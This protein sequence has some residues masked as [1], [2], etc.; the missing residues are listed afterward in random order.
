M[1]GQTNA[2]CLQS[3]NSIP[4]AF[5]HGDRNEICSN[6]CSFIGSSS[7]RLSAVKKDVTPPEMGLLC[8]IKLERGEKRRRR[9]CNLGSPRRGF[10]AC[11]GVKD[12]N[13]MRV[14][15]F[16]LS[17]PQEREEMWPQM[18]KDMAAYE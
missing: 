18:D 10:K 16:L 9:Q 1:G 17:I 7:F 8:W 5:F 3:S 4:A 15:S 12:L 13:F 6:S 2:A 11:L 14:S